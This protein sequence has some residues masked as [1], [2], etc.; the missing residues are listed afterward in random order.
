MLGTEIGVEMVKRDD[1]CDPNQTTT[2]RAQGPG[3]WGIQLTSKR[4]A[5]WI[6]LVSAFAVAGLVAITYQQ[7]KLLEAMQTTIQSTA[8]EN[9]AMLNRLEASQRYVACI[10][11]MHEGQ[12]DNCKAVAGSPP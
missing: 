1:E 3:G 10:M 11:V 5:E 4:M 2:F 6:S 8:A 7:Y 12:R 9:R